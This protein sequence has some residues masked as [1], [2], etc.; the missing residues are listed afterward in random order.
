MTKYAMVETLQLRGTLEGHNGWVTSLSTCAQSP[1]VLISG[2]RDKT[3]MVWQLTPDSEEEYAHAKRSLRGHSHIVEDVSISQDGC[4]VISA[5][6]DKTLRLWDLNDGSSQ[7]FVGH[8]GDVLSCDFASDNRMVVS[9]SRD[10]TIKVWNVIGDT[11]YTI[12]GAHAHSDWVSSVRITPHLD[13]FK[14]ISAGHDKLVKVSTNKDNGGDDVIY[15]CYFRVASCGNEAHQTTKIS[16]PDANFTGMGYRQG[17]PSSRLRRSRGIRIL[18]NSCTRWNPLCISWQG[19]CHLH[20]VRLPIAVHVLSSWWRGG[21]CS[22]ILPISLLACCCD[23]LF[24]QDLRLARACGTRGAAPRDLHLFQGTCASVPLMVCR[25]PGSFR[26]LQ[27]Q[28]HSCLASHAIS[29]SS[30]YKHLIY[31]CFL[32]DLTDLLMFQ[33]R[34]SEKGF[35]RVKNGK[36][37]DAHRHSLNVYIRYCVKLTPVP[38][39]VKFHVLSAFGPPADV[40]AGRAP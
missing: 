6:W 11:L 14:I 3:V 30:R 21:E 12:E 8:T 23:P 33:Y 40:Y 7:R 19:R 5:S 32:V 37:D 24:H 10:K 9:G 1:D 15:F 4:Y 20:V 38:G 17:F 13:E 39:H 29:V 34:H 27:R 28:Q 16:D 35:L 31:S 18:R 36:I 2:S 26:R 22:R 25:W